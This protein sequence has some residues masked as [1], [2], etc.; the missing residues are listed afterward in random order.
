[1]ADVEVNV[2]GEMEVPPEGAVSQPLSFKSIM[3]LPNKLTVPAATEWVYQRRQNVRPWTTF[4]S[5]SRFKTPASVPRLTRRLVKNIEYFQSNYLFVFIGLVI[6]CL[7]T[8]PLLLIA[9]AASLGACYVLALKHAERKLVIMGKELSLAQ[10]YMM[11][12]ICSIPVFIWAGAQAA[13]FWVIGASVFT[14]SL[15]AAFY[16]IEALL[17]PEEEFDLV[18]Q[19][20]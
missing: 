2:S 16:N 11:V 14:I 19:Q 7:L 6:F 15:H 10:Q 20:V 12:C 9:V 13:V 17:S 4:C 5:T 3:Q 1:M 18:M 8:S